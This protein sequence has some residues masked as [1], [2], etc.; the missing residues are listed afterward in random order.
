MAN[1]WNMV[2]RTDGSFV[3]RNGRC[4]VRKA[5]KQW[6]VTLD[7]KDHTITAKKPGFGH[8]EAILRRELGKMV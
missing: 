1:Q 3:S 5:G 2:K 4:A 8:V 7:G 6:I